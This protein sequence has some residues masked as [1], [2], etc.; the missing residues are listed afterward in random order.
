MDN[1]K[2]QIA[3]VILVGN[4]AHQAISPSSRALICNARYR[5]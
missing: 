3:A 2:L 1:N 4:T 5:E